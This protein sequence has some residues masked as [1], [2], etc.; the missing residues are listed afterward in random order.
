MSRDLAVIFNLLDM[1]VLRKR[2][3]MVIGECDSVISV[4]APFFCKGI[5]NVILE[6]LDQAVF[7]ADGASLLDSIVLGPDER[8]ISR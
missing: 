7:M 6:P 2:R 1:L 5:I 4:L 3:N 8:S